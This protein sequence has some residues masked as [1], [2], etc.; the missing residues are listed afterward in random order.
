M[1]WFLLFRHLPSLLQVA[2][3]QCCPR[4]GN[5]IFLVLFFLNFFFLYYWAFL[6][7]LFIFRFISQLYNIFYKILVL[8]RKCKFF[9]KE[10]MTKQKKAENKN[11]I[12]FNTRT[13]FHWIFVNK[14]QLLAFVWRFIGVS[15]W[16]QFVNVRIF[17]HIGLISYGGYDIAKGHKLSFL[18][19]KFSRVADKEISE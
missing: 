1:Y 19:K 9:F 11:F 18:T 2:S 14:W 15:T 16:F 12:F 13:I 8:C 17:Y 5:S 3:L 7:K 6:L 10:G 4:W